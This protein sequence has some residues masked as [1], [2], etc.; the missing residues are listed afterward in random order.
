MVG[1]YLSYYKNEVIKIVEVR[2]SQCNKLLL[3]VDHVEGEIKCPRC[4]KIN[5]LEVIKDRA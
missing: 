5:K 2:C 1:I 3:K 4:K